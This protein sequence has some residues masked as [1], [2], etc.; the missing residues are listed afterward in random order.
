MT[1]EYCDCGDNPNGPLRRAADCPIHGNPLMVRLARKN[2]GR[3]AEKHT[4]KRVGGRQTVASGAVGDKADIDTVHFL[5]E[6]KCTIAESM[7]VKVEWL[8]KL[9]LEAASVGKEPALAI[10][11]VDG[12]G[13][14]V[15][16]GC[17]VLLPER[18]LRE[19]F[20]AQNAPS[21]GPGRS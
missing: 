3:R 16:D 14:A 6:N 15:K 7:S 9:A 1:T 21:E 20:N 10:Q 12:S 19:I 5:I 2:D 13:R 8:R 4:A 18:L 17:W 11:F